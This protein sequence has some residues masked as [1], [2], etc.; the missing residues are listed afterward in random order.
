MSEVYEL[1]LDYEGGGYPEELLLPRAWVELNCQYPDKDWAP[2]GGME[3]LWQVGWLSLPYKM[4]GAIHH[5]AGMRSGRPINC[6][7]QI[8]MVSEATNSP[9]SCMEPFH[10]RVENSICSS[11]LSTIRI[12]ISDVQKVQCV[13][14]GEGGFPAGP[15]CGW[16]HEII[17]LS[18]S[19]T[20]N[21]STAQFIIL[22]GRQSR[23]SNA[24]VI[25]VR[26]EVTKLKM[27]LEWKGKDEKKKRGECKAEFQPNLARQTSS[28][29]SCTKHRKMFFFSSFQ[30]TIGRVSTLTRASR[31]SVPSPRSPRTPSTSSTASRGA[32]SSSIGQC[33]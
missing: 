19:K 20:S 7:L 21:D 30:P 11:T 32:G 15:E 14:C 18:P 28:S 33:E 29:C 22:P 3:S 27:Y 26:H 9:S 25:Q 4:S 6:P 5:K 1:S 31:A 13:E 24:N 2:R 12:S 16:F 23:M 17:I 10:C 8:Q